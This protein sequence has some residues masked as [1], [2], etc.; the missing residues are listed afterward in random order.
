MALIKAKAQSSNQ[1]PDA[2]ILG[3]LLLT[4]PASFATKKHNQVRSEV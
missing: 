3:T 4:L 1:T 2:I